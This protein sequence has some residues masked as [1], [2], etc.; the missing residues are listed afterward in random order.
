MADQQHQAQQSAVP[1]PVRGTGEAAA[2]EAGGTIAALGTDDAVARVPY[3]GNDEMAIQK[4]RKAA[5]TSHVQTS[6]QRPEG[7]PNVVC[8]Y[9]GK[10]GH[11]ERDCRKKKQ[12]LD[13]GIEKPS[14]T[15]PNSNNSSIRRGPG[16]GWGRGGHQQ[17]GSNAHT[18]DQYQQFVAWQKAQAQQTVAAPPPPPG[19][20]GSNA[21]VNATA[22][23][24]WA[25]IVKTWDDYLLW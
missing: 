10:R 2:P 9:C 12:D 15:G 7:A 23:P 19:L 22:G 8:H 18:S 5:G 3:A 11:Y 17:G 21:A 6:G 25:D 4:P 16:R 24:A 1:G 20:G 13:N 14:L